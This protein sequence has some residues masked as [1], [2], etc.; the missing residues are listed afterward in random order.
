[1]S[2]EQEFE[3]RV[4]E[5]HQPNDSYKMEEKDIRHEEFQVMADVFLGKDYN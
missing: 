3:R 2:K 5:I 1:M 4:M